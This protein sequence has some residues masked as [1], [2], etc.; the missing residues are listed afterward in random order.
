MSEHME[1]PYQK[2]IHV[3]AARSWNKR[4]ESASLMEQSGLT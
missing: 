2:K 4:Q 1:A 3:I